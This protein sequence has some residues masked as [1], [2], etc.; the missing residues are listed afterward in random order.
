MCPD[1]HSLHACR[2]QVTSAGV[3]TQ[4]LADSSLQR[5]GM[6]T[7]NVA[8]SP[9]V[10]PHSTLTVEH[11]AL[12]R[13]HANLQVHILAKLCEMSPSLA[14]VLIFHPGWLPST[15]RRHRN[16]ECLNF[17]ASG[18]GQ[19][20]RKFCWRVARSA[21]SIFFIFRIDAWTPSQAPLVA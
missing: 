20:R 7:P 21:R 2:A 16:P 15:E 5:A 13:S 4:Y 19:A 10:T 17:K 6:A 3:S 14:H 8:P 12:I 11:V 9:S 1:E 18:S